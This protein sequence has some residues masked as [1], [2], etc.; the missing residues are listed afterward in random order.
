MHP[1]KCS[2]YVDIPEWVII[3]ELYEGENS[4]EAFE[5]DLDRALEARPAAIIVEPR[6]LGEE[7]ARWIA[8][9][10]CLHQTSVLSGL[11][12]LAAT[13]LLSPPAPNPA[14][15]HTLLIISTPLAAVGTLCAGLYS[16]S[17]ATDPCIH[18]QVET[19]TQVLSRLPLSELANAHPLVLVRK[20]DKK[21]R[22]AHIVTTALAVGAVVWKL[23]RAV[24]E[25]VDVE[26]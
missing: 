16:V 5:S 1:T 21:K 10:N 17:W 18:Y 7:T 3:H 9:G 14:S 19:D 24:K 23:Y 20:D 6:R 11:G 2:E 4:H 22:A 26:S 13:L 15:I 8:L 25:G 12:S